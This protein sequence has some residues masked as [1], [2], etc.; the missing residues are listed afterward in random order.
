[1]PKLPTD[2]SQHNLPLQ[3]TS[4]VGRERELARI[5]EMLKLAGS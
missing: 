1:L 4:F 3:P 5:A 2:A